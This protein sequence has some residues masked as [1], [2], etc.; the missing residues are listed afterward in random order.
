[1]GGSPLDAPPTR[2]LAS[3]IVV[4]P[5]LPLGAPQ[6]QLHQQL[7][8]RRNSAAVESRA[9][10]WLDRK[11]DP[12][13]TAGGLSAGFYLRFG[14]EAEFVV[15]SDGRLIRWHAFAGEADDTVVHL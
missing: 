6:T 3:G 13:M 1:M 12:W 15:R 4:D 5:D 7:T 14:D 8:V 11:S 10:T 2:E 9:V